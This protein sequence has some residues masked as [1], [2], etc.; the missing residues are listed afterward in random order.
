MSLSQAAISFNRLLLFTAIV[1]LAG[2]SRF[3][4]NPSE[5]PILP[6]P[7]TATVYFCFF[8]LFYRK[9]IALTT[10][11]IPALPTLELFPTPQ[12]CS[13]FSFVI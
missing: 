4:S 8:M 5:K 2:C 11:A 13:P 10:A 9:F 6:V 3:E 1:W 12:T 7:M